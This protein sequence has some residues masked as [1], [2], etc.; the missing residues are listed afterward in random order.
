MKT[1]GIIWSVVK[2]IITLAVVLGIFSVAS[3]NFETVILA[4]L[5]LIY[6][7][8]LTFSTLMGLHQVEFGKALNREFKDIK[9]LLSQDDEGYEYTKEERKET[10]KQE[11]NLLIKVWINGIFQTI[12]YIITLYNLLTSL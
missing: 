12:I 2:N 7:S 1:L 3:T 5:V 11:L 8:I 10:E 9:K 6:L 4:V